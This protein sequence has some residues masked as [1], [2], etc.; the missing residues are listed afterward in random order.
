MQ[1]HPTKAELSIVTWITSQ[2]SL[3]FGLIAV[4]AHKV[5]CNDEVLMF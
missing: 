4:P 5:Q 3:L 1:V 2:V